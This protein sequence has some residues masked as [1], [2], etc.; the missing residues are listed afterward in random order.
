VAPVSGPA[1]WLIAY[2]TPS[3]SRRRK[4]SALLAGCGFRVQGS[5]FLAELTTK[6]ASLLRREL[7]GIVAVVDRVLMVCQCAPCAEKSWTAGTPWERVPPD[8]IVV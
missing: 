3:A 6:Q 4:L 1:S 7:E 2:D 5:V 8:M